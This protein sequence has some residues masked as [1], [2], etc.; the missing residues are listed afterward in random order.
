[1]SDSL[2]TNTLNHL[3]DTALTSALMA[4]IG[5]LC[6]RAVIH[7]NSSWQMDPRVGLAS[8]AAAGAI[9]GLFGTTESNTS[10]KIVACVALIFVPFKLCQKLEI[11]ASFKAVLAITATTVVISGL[12][13]VVLSVFD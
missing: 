12:V 4:G 11:P 2:I 6:A 10:S 13:M 1:M 3:S 7:L 8:G 9:I 5:Y